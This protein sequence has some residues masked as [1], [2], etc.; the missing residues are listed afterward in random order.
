[1]MRDSVSVFGGLVPVH[2]LHKL[3]QGFVPLERNPP[4]DSASSLEEYI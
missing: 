4:S 1:M 2:K 3:S